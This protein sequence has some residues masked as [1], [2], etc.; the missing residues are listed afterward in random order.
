MRALRRA[1]ADKLGVTAIEFAFLAPAFL[2]FVIGA[3]DAGRAL[4]SQATLQRTVEVAA[5]CAAI[6]KLKCA[7]NSQVQTLASEL[8]LFAP[9]SA[10]SVSSETCGV[11]VSASLEYALSSSLMGM[12][13]IT[14]T[15][16]ACYP[17]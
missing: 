2:L 3:M 9:A 17:Q 4:W 7:T 8:S 5:R 11:T 14:L 16:R 15:A 1:F 13:N 6:D 12:P 10:F